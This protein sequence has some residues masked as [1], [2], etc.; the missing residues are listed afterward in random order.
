MQGSDLNVLNIR[1]ADAHTHKMVDVKV[2]GDL[3]GII[4]QGDTIAVW[5]NIQ[6]GLLVMQRAHNYTTG[7]DIA[8]RK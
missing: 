3:H 4:S 7:H 8:V 6:K 2:M 1:V 5:G